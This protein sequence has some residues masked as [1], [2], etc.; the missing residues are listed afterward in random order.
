MDLRHLT[1][2][3]QAGFP[4]GPLAADQP[5]RLSTAGGRFWWEKDVTLHNASCCDLHPD[6]LVTDETPTTAPLNVCRHAAELQPWF[7]LLEK[8]ARFTVTAQAAVEEAR[9]LIRDPATAVP[10]HA[11]AQR[12][13]HAMRAVPNDILDRW[14]SSDVPT[15]VATWMTGLMARLASA[16][17]EFATRWRDQCGTGNE[18]RYTLFR[19]PHDSDESL[20]PYVAADP[21]WSL[22]PG[23]SGHIGSWTVRVTTDPLSA[24][25]R[26]DDREQH[27]AFD[28]G[29]VGEP[30]PASFWAAYGDLLRHNPAA[31]VAQDLFHALA[32]AAR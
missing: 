8:V 28:L 23:G 7:D 25:W 11:L 5:V 2:L 21:L 15:D 6:T 30:L 18:P 10:V 12:T 26:T 24:S 32:T 3:R 19:V 20:G 31:H 14:A 13:H 22:E 4:M 29:P 27:L 16:R 17:Q 1:A 9:A